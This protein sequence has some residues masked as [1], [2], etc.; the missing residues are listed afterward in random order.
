MHGTR[1]KEGRD[2]HSKTRL[3]TWIWKEGRCGIDE[4][5]SRFPTAPKWQT[6]GVGVTGEKNVDMKFTLILLSRDS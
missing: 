6:I 5:S 2:P 1:W 3:E 4:S